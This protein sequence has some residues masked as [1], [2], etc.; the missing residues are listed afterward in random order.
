MIS[1]KIL[2]VQRKSIMTHY[3]R[4]IKLL[5]IA[6]TVTLF[7]FII[8]T[9]AMPISKVYTTDYLNCLTDFGRLFLLSFPFMLKIGKRSVLFSSGQAILVSIVVPLVNI[10]LVS[11]SR[12]AK[13]INLSSLVVKCFVYLLLVALFIYI[14]LA[15]DPL[16]LLLGVTVLMGLDLLYAALFLDYPTAATI[17][18]IVY[19]VLWVFYPFLI[20]LQYIQESNAIRDL[21]SLRSS[22]YIDSTL[23]VWASRKSSF[24]LGIYN[25]KLV[26]C[27]PTKKSLDKVQNEA[28]LRITYGNRNFVRCYGFT[29]VDSQLYF[30]VER[31]SYSLQD[32][33][34][35]VS[36]NRFRLTSV[37]YMIDCAKALQYVH[38]I[39]SNCVYKNLSIAS[40]EYADDGFVKLKDLGQSD[41][42]IIQQGNFVAPELTEILE[43]RIM[44][45]AVDIFSLA[46]VFLEILYPK[47]KDHTVAWPIFHQS[48]MTAIPGSS[49]KMSD[50]LTK[51]LAKDPQTRPSIHD[52]VADLDI[53]FYEYFKDVMDRIHVE[54]FILGSTLITTVLDN[55]FA[56]N[57]KE[58]DRLCHKLLEQNIIKHVAQVPLLSKKMLKLVGSSTNTSY[59]R[60]TSLSDSSIS[61]LEM[62]LSGIEFDPDKYYKINTKHSRPPSHAYTEIPPDPNDHRPDLT[63][64]PSSVYFGYHL[65]PDQE[66]V[67]S[68]ETEF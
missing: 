67:L 38:S 31:T 64:G 46:I 25:E 4:I 54:G 8:T 50:L 36:L 19:Q 21:L 26:A 1:A 16:F 62:D 24:K 11:L 28:L 22:K 61:S 59:L 32:F 66:T 48:F 27:I 37:L 39:D 33:L 43:A 63:S 53:I 40:F 58:A 57:E 23:I 30:V 51:M 17:C 15:R 9:Y 35:K 2:Q 34:C 47:E 5:T 29:M 55:N 45:Q 10:L 68:R 3:L 42:K 52:V 41:E 12:D 49:A 7:F 44:T 65:E 13:T 18:F 20:L 14:S 56:C 60:T 6:S